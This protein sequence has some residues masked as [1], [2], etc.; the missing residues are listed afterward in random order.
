MQVVCL[1]WSPLGSLLATWEQYAVI[2]GQQPQPNLHLWDAKTGQKVKSFFQK[3]MSGWCPQWSSEE[4]IC[5]R[6]VNNEVQFYE[7]NNFQ[8]IADKIHMPKVANYSMAQCSS[9]SLHV[10]TYVP[11]SK[12][13]PSFSKMFQHP[14]FEDSQV[15]ANKSFFQADSVEFK[16]NRPGTVVLLLTQSEVDKTG[17]SYYGKQ[18]L[19]YMS[20]KVRLLSLLI[21]L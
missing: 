14:N 13:G 21:F 5:S 1:T 18:Q 19:N 16:W 17:G 4:R 10:V 2:Q 9:K 15:I 12:G 20:V 3:K 6:M 11:G 7:D 8:A